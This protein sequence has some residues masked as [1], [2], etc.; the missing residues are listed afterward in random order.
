VD[1]AVCKD[2]PCA[3]RVFDGVFC[4]AVVTGD[5]ADCTGEMLAVEGWFDVL[6][7]ECLEK[8]VV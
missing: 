2:N 3:G 4:A 8:E 7:C 1:F 5:T 6:D